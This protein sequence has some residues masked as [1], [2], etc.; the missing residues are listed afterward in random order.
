M[1]AGQ[2]HA[3]AREV[4]GEPSQTRHDRVGPLLPLG[5]VIRTSGLKLVAIKARLRASLDVL[6]RMR[7]RWVQQVTLG[8]AAALGV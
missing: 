3:L 2:D 1:F 5:C 6:F 4:L 8:V 7:H